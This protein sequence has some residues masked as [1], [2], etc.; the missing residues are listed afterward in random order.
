[1]LEMGRALRLEEI[2]EGVETQAQLDDLRELAP[3]GL[4]CHAQGF[5]LRTTDN[6]P[7]VRPAAAEAP[8]CS[9]PADLAGFNR[10]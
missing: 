8:S 4:S 6:R 2:A 10:R 3:V 5:L 7:Q 9:P 1:M